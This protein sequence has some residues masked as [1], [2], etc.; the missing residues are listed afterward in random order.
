[1]SGPGATAARPGRAAGGVGKGARSRPSRAAFHLQVT[2]PGLGR[3]DAASELAGHRLRATH[4]ELVAG[5]EPGGSRHGTI[6]PGGDPG[7]EGTRD[8]TTTSAGKGQETGPRLGGQGKG[9][10]PGRDKRQDQGREGITDGTRTSTGQGM[11]PEPGGNNGL[12]L[13]MGSDVVGTLQ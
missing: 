7:R 6:G 11:E 5:P 4:H 13:V 12:N 9:P 2:G 1:M 8:G 10:E 3:G